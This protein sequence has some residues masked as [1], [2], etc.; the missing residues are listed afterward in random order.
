[1]AILPQINRLN[2]RARDAVWAAVAAGIFAL[3]GL[4][5]PLDQS[6]WIYQSIFSDEQMSGDIVFATSR[7][8]LSD[9]AKPQQRKRL[10]SALDALGESGVDHIYIDVVFDRPSTPEADARL[11]QAIERLGD[12]VT[13]VRRVETYIAGKTWVQTT[14]EPI[15]GDTRQVISDRVVNYMGFT[16]EMPLVLETRAG[17]FE[18]LPAALAD[19]ETSSVR[20]TLI[21]YDFD[22]TSMKVIEIDEDIE[23]A[24]LA[25]LAGKRVLFGNRGAKAAELANIPGLPGVPGSYVS[26]FAA[27]TLKAG[28][29]KYLP[30]WLAWAVAFVVLF[31]ITGLWRPATELRRKAYALFALAVPATVLLGTHFHI[32]VSVASAL[33][34]GV[35][36]GGLRLRSRW[37]RKF[38]LEDDKT[39]LPTFRAFEK[40]IA[41]KGAPSAV[42]V[43]KVHGYEEVVKA[44]PP[45]LHSEYV[46]NMVERLRVTEKGMAIYATEGRYFSWASAETAPQDIEEHLNGLRAL[47]ATPISVG[48]TELDAGMTF[49]VD[50]SGEPNPARRIAS[51]VSAAEKTDE[52]HRPIIFAEE[53]NQS[54]ALWKLSLQGRIDRA[55]DRGEIY[56]V[57]QPKV[58]ISTG[59]MV[60]VEALVRWNDPA[61]GQ[62]SPAFFIQECERAGRMDHLTQFV[63][64]EAVKAAVLLRG[65]G[66]DAKMS[67]NIS[68]TLLRDNR[69]ERMVQQTLREHN[70][71][72]HLLVLELTETAR[73]LD[74]DHAVTVLERLRLT[75]CS[76][77]IDDF[78]VGAAN[79]EVIYKLPLDELKIDR[80]F[81][82]NVQNP[83]AAAVI[84]SMIAFGKAAG[85]VVIAEGAEDAQTIRNL[86]DL[87]CNIIQGYGISR[88]VELADLLQ[89]QW[90][91]TKPTAKNMV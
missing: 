45:D 79:L 60:G 70:L 17:R 59:Q 90:T 11:A 31:L 1:M 12:R 80:E 58:D 3:L 33:M 5:G 20:S 46:H 30:A 78:G 27:E 53:S 9:P 32:R 26:I 36:Y 77:S 23:P 76:I 49:G 18:T 56:L 42:I 43:A 13:L 50:M 10:A 35:W 55:L 37:Q 47:F 51:A 83:K 84:G 19:A 63:L 89:F 38:A 88:P 28:Y 85:I 8:S 16:W 64:D 39:G 75:G 52:A 67:V 82:A 68:A 24:T 44:L 7:D 25:S 21:N 69:V 57:Y 65:H 61:R 40:L 74:L 22:P 72:A 81:V 48:D 86:A 91:T 15:A 87:G 71:P 14:I 4:L 34:T 41:E 62:I 54:D 29:A 66:I 2:E 6:I 73:I